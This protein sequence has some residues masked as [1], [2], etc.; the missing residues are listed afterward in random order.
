L[1]KIEYE[2]TPGLGRGQLQTSFAMMQL[3]MQ[4]ILLLR[5]DLMVWLPSSWQVSS[6]LSIAC[7]LPSMHQPSPLL[8]SC[9]FSGYS[10]I[11]MDLGL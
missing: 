3:E 6:L 1:H 4:N 5:L 7:R 9:S 2:L 8:V 11:N 10:S